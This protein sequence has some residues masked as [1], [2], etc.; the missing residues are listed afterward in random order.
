MH[1]ADVV[2]DCE[3]MN[4][5]SKGSQ[6]IPDTYEQSPLHLLSGTSATVYK[7]IQSL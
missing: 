5:V 6:T 7:M 2:A 4:T 3:W 1:N